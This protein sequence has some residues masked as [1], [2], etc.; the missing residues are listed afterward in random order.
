MG[1]MSRRGFVE[2]AGVV[3][4][5]VCLSSFGATA[6]AEENSAEIEWTDEADLV[7]IGTGGA[8]L[9]AAAAVGMEGL[10]DCLVLEAAPEEEQGGNTRVSGQ[11]LF[12]AD[13]VEHALAYQT[14]MNEPYV[15]DE[16]I[17][18]VWAEGMVENI[19]WFEGLGADFSDESYF[20]G[21]E[22]SEFPE[23][24]GY[25]CVRNGGVI[26]D[27]ALW[28]L[29]KAEVDK[30]DFPFYYNSRAM[31]LIQNAAGEVVGVSTED[32]RNFKARKA[33]ILACGGFEHNPDMMAKY[34]PAGFNR[35]TGRGSWWDV[36]DGSGISFGVH[37]LTP[38]DDNAVGRIGPTGANWVYLDCHG[39]RFMNEDYF[40]RQKH[41]KLWR[42]GQ[43]LDVD[44][45]DGCFCL[46]GQE[47]FEGT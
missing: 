9:G 36:G 31:H 10:G 42:N 7:I 11:F 6:F 8:G 38:G 28:Q 32:G 20:T 44:V 35:T 18:Q 46:M 30:Y 15:I 45:P 37:M 1:E 12:Y 4:A 39:N 40:S 24:E 25:G 5:A 41:G 27:E 34:R 26:D 13:S 21:A 2:G 19:S 16:D 14:K 17:M 23:S 3:G 47:A 43:W 29:V 22:F 33:V